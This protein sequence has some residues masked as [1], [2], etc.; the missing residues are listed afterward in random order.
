MKAFLLLMAIAFTGCIDHH[1]TNEFDIQKISLAATELIELNLSNG[2][3]EA[4]W[5]PVSIVALKPTAARKTQQGI[6]IQLRSFL[7]EESG[8]FFPAYTDQF[9]L[10]VT[11]DPSFSRLSQSIYSY[12]IKG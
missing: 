11:N 6:Y 12:H 5:W 1:S 9:G 7:S 8:L 10:E 2:P 4:Q 3:I